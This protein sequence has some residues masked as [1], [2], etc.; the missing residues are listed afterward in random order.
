M[1]KGKG[2]IGVNPKPKKKNLKGDVIPIL[3]DAPLSFDFSQ[4]DW[5]KS[6]NQKEFTNKLESENM[7]AKYIFEL[8]YKLIPTI[9]QNWKEIIRS[10]GTGNWKHCHPVKEEKLDSVI[11][12]LEH[13]HGHQFRT[14]ATSG[15]S[16]WQFGISQ[17][18]RLIAIHD[19]KNNFLTPVF[20]DYHHQIHPS[21]KYNKTEYSRYEFCPFCKYIHNKVV[22]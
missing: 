3:S 8:F 6:I 18:I 1:R 7:F 15:P 22:N 17:N 12:I 11:H 20:I 10:A 4:K 9:Q 19:Y 21:I 5:L 2:K 13:I 14:A 16:L